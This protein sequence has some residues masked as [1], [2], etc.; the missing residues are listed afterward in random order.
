MCSTRTGCPMGVGQKAA[1]RGSNHTRRGAFLDEL[2][3][4]AWSTVQACEGAEANSR[5]RSG[6]APPR[7][8]QSPPLPARNSS[9][10]LVQSRSARI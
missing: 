7:A 5:T 4:R 3:L 9:L 6:S 10:R 2:A 8:S 1:E